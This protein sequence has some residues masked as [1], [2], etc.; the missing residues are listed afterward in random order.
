MDKIRI[1]GIISD[2]IEH[3]KKP[4]EYYI[5]GGCYIFATYLKTRIKDIQIYYLKNEYHFIV[6]YQKKLYDIT[7]NVTNKYK[8]S[9]KISEE[10]M[11]Q[12]Y[13]KLIKQYR[14]SE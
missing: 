8:E 13:P 14:K 6:E 3:S 10:E 7:G 12:R 1:L 2:F 11:I 4:K 9:K 5:H